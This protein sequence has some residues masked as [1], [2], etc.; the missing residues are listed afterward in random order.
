M[1]VGPALTAVTTN[2]DS[3]PATLSFAQALGGSWLNRPWTWII[4]VF[5]N[6]ACVAILEASLLDETWNVLA[7]TALLQFAIAVA[8]LASSVR[9]ARR[10]N[11]IVSVPLVFLFL[12]LTAIAQALIGG[13]YAATV[14]GGS[15]DFGLRIAFWLAV[16]WLWSPLVIL[17]LA[18]YEHRRYLLAERLIHIDSC[19]ANAEQGNIALRNQHVRLLET[20]R[21]TVSPVIS[22]IRQQLSG[23]RAPRQQAEF[24]R[25]AEQLTALSNSVKI[26]LETPHISST[27]AWGVP[28]H[29]RRIAPII[30]AVN[31]EI[32]RPYV[33][34]AILAILLLPVLAPGVFRL[35]GM[36]AIAELA[37]GVASSA[38]LFA[39]GLQ[40]IKLLSKENSRSRTAQNAVVHVIASIAAPL[41][42]GTMSWDPLGEREWVLL[43]LLPVGFL[44]A[45]VTVSGAFGLGD[46][47]RVLVDDMDQIRGRFGTFQHFVRE[48][49]KRM[50]D[51]VESV[52]HGPIRGRLSACIMALKFHVEEL[53]I[54]DSAH[55]QSIMRAVSEHLE[56]TARDLDRMNVPTSLTDRASADG[57][58]HH[59]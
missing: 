7:T 42:V 39:S 59:D 19:N 11:L 24:L 29:S 18:Q 28:E 48:E 17:T 51:E 38:F 49:E 32:R 30:D 25:T 1:P 50:S 44:F 33:S 36:P 58:K 15:S 56:D 27:L 45:A 5:P 3:V 37:V 43:L 23:N 22:E 21:A 16:Q 13:V 20:I 41:V 31:Y 2:D 54:A 57:V 4:G 55:G 53:A 46:A 6:T 10:R 40:I 12:A 47:N 8:V 26:I 14:I 9:L 52:L 35:G 34:S